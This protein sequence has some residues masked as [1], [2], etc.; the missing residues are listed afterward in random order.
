M[1]KLLLLAANLILIACLIACTSQ[2]SPRS[3]DIGNS[4]DSGQITTEKAQQ[5]LNQWVTSAGGG[6]VSI[7]GGVRELPT[8]NAATADLTLTG[9]TWQSS[10]TKQ[11][12][13]Y[14]GAGK[15]MFVHYTDGRWVL[16]KVTVGDVWANTS[17]TPNIEIR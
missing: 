6:Q 2:S 7:V 15:A 14:S 3:T 13:H 9:L 16:S 11:T 10:Q 5:A 1:K 17:W 4:S 12:R 8:E